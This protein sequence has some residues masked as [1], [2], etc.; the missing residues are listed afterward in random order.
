MD[1]LVPSI[2]TENIGPLR[3]DSATLTYHYQSATTLRLEV[4]DW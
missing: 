3:I 2:D 1:T 4:L